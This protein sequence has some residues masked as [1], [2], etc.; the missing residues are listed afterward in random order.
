MQIYI[1]TNVAF[2]CKQ[3]KM[4]IVYL[5]N[6]CMCKQI[7]IIQNRK[8]SKKKTKK[9]LNKYEF[10]FVHRQFIHRICFLF[11]YLY[12][13]RKKVIIKRYLISHTHSLYWFFFCSSICS[14]IFHSFFVFFPLIFAIANNYDDDDDDDDE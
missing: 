6:G 10:F 1:T 11:F 4:N 14:S 3:T 12:I 2:I 8:E 5:Y 13:N 7:L 9:I